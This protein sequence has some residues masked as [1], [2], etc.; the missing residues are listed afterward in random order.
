MSL[1]MRKNLAELA[2]SADTERDQLGQAAQLE[3]LERTLALGRIAMPSQFTEQPDDLTDSTGYHRFC[4]DCGTEIPAGRIKTLPFCV[5]CT[6][7]QQAREH[8][9]KQFASVNSRSFSLD[10]V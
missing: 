2:N 6:A 4:L 5:R 3:E 8:R 7:C 9:G 1:A 10:E